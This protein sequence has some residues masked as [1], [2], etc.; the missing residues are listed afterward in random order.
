M[1]KGLVCVF[2]AVEPCGP[3]QIAHGK[4]RLRIEAARRKCLFLYFYYLDPKLGLIHVRIQT[5]FPFTIQVYLNGHEWLARKMDKCGLAYRA[6]DNA[7]GWLEDPGRA[8][9]G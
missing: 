8:Q 2:T 3:F 4:G 7:F 1:A 6:V 9:E 5:W